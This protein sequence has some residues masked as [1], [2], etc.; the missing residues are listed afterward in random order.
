MPELG[1]KLKTTLVPGWA[2]SNWWPR[3]V[4]ASVSEAAA[5]TV[6]VLVGPAAADDD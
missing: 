6:I 4:K 1:P 5:M 2:A 3:V